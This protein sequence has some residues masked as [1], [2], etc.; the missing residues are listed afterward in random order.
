MSGNS[1][2]EQHKPYVPEDTNLPELTFRAVAV[3]IVLAAILG[4]ANAAVGMKAGLTVA[5]TFPAAVIALAVVRLWKGNILE[6]NIIRTTASVGEA[7]VA[8]AI[9]TV[10]AFVLLGYWE[11]LLEPAN[12]LEGSMLLLIGGVLGVLFVIVLRRALITESDLLFPESVAAASIHKA[13]QKGATGAGL[14][15]VSMITAMVVEFFKHGSGVVLIRERVEG[16]VHFA[17]S[18]IG[19][20]GKDYAFAGGVAWRT[21]NASRPS[22]SRAGSWPG[23]S[24][25]R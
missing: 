19:L 9:F 4:A 6:E 3:G 10:P 8:G 22:T 21:L 15:L 12:Y 17:K 18:T 1:G 14:V 7:L 16:F 20:G 13:G 25:C 5:A 24:S 11:N 2:K 23:V